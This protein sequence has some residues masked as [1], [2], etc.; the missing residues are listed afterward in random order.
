MLFNMSL[1]FLSCRYLMLCLKLYLTL[2]PKPLRYD[3]FLSLHKE[4]ICQRVC[5]GETQEHKLH[6]YC[7]GLYSGTH[8][9][10]VELTRELF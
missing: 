1:R 8:F 2:L 6:F 4:S 9:I 3:S 10:I 7:I 5:N